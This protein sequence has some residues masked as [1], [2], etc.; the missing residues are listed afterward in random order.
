MERENTLLFEFKKFFYRV[1]LFVERRTAE[2]LDLVFRLCY[3]Q[4]L[5]L[6]QTPLFLKVQ[7]CKLACLNNVIVLL[8]LLIK[9]LGWNDMLLL[10]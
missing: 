3:L 10:T 5:Q 8:F 9:R 1:L 6:F 4:E 7:C 2:R